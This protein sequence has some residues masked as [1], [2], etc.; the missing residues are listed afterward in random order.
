MG[1]HFPHMVNQRI[2][3]HFQ[4]MLFDKAKLQFSGLNQWRNSS[5]YYTCRPIFMKT[6]PLK[7]GVKIIPFDYFRT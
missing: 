7:S 1:R 5:E 6:F 3:F 4:N 2:G